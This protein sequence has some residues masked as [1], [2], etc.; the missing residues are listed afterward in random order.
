VAVFV[1][2]PLYLAVAA[3]IMDSMSTAHADLGLSAMV[4]GHFLERT[5]DCLF[6][7]LA[8]VGGAGLVGRWSARG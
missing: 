6:V 8:C 2:I 5:L 4:A 1:L 7:V 3:L